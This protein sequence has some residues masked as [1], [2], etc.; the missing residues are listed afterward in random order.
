MN[1]FIHFFCLC[2]L[3]LTIELNFNI[4]GTLHRSKISSSE[5][6]HWFLKRGENRSTHRKTSRSGVENQRTKPTFDAASL[7][8][9]PGRHLWEE[10]ALTS[11]IDFLRS[12]PTMET[13]FCTLKSCRQRSWEFYF[14]HFK[15]ALKTY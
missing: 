12:I 4:L 14:K 15:G 6:K 1:M 7:E 2:P 13:V 3:S 9:E 8:T 10:S 5:I 11:M